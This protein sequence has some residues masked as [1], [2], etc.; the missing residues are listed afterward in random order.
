MCTYFR[1]FH[2][3][4]ESLFERIDN[5]IETIVDTNDSVEK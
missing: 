1:D 5:Y 4:C 2:T 3:K